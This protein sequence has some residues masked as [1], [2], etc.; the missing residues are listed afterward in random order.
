MAQKVVGFKAN[1]DTP[2]LHGHVF[3]EPYVVFTSIL[4]CLFPAYCAILYCKKVV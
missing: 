3:E 4:K 1:D 2:Q